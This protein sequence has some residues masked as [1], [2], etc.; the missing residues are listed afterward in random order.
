MTTTSTATTIPPARRP[1]PP[2]GAGRPR[3]RRGAPRRL[4]HLDRVLFTQREDFTGVAAPFYEG[5][6]HAGILPRFRA[7]NAALARRATAGG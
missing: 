3:R 4:C 1:A 2:P 5:R 7:V 6:L